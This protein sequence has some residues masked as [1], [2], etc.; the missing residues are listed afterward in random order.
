MGVDRGDRSEAQAQAICMTTQDFPPRRLRR[1]SRS[2]SSRAIE[3]PTPLAPRLAVLRRTATAN[4]RAHLGA[5]AAQPWPRRTHGRRRRRSAARWCARSGDG[6]LAAPLR[7]AA[8]PGGAADVIDTRDLPAARRWP[9]TT[10][11]PTS[12]SRCRAG[13]RRDLAGR[14]PAQRQRFLP[15]V[16]A[17]PA[18]AAVSRCPNP[19]PDQLRR[20]GDGL[21]AARAATAGVP[22]A[23]RPGSQRR[24]RRRLIASSRDDRPRTRRRDLGVRRFALARAGFEIRR[25]HRGD[26]LHPLARLFHPLPAPRARWSARPAKASNWRCTLGHLPRLGGGGGVGLHTARAGRTAARDEAAHVRPACWP[27]SSSPRPS[28]RRW[29]P[30]STGRHA[31]H[32]SRRLAAATGRQRDARRR[33]WPRWFSPRGRGR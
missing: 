16:A 3:M 29:R 24:H 26:R 7:W 14:H 33:R 28:W 12:P 19:R 5:W 15:R 10:G 9:S 13:L 18:I 32:L 2:R 27:T 30:P 23:R 6:W 31:A 17:G 11:W 8:R 1:Q 20:G 21:P 25:A 22:T 4:W